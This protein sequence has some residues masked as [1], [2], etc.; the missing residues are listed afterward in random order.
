MSM[1]KR[2][3]KRLSVLT[4]EFGRAVGQALQKNEQMQA[5]RNILEKEIFSQEGMRISRML[6]NAVIQAFREA[7]GKSE[8]ELKER[9]EELVAEPMIEFQ[10]FILGI[11]MKH[12]PNENYAALVPSALRNPDDADKLERLGAPRIAQLCVR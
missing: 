4:E 6:D 8:Q 9:F 5:K 1:D 11:A 7:G 3:I 10:D 12:F 2:E